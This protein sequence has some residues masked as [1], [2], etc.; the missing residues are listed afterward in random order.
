MQYMFI[1]LF[2][3]KNIIVRLFIVILPYFN[4]KKLLSDTTAYTSAE[5]QLVRMCV[6]YLYNCTLFTFIFSW[7]FKFKWSEG[8]Q[9]FLYSSMAQ[10]FSLWTTGF[11]V[12]V[13]WILQNFDGSKF[14][15]KTWTKT[16]QFFH[17]GCI[18]ESDVTVKLCLAL[19]RLWRLP[20]HWTELWH[21]VWWPTKIKV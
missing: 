10:T 13:Q 4:F 18:T 5:A 11:V 9:H 16:R 17:L 1:F 2:Q 15:S 19:N 14:Y 6:L 20:A 8:K 3:N 21:I 12:F 7:M